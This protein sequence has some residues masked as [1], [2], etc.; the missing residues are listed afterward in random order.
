M[1]KS[2]E[3]IAETFSDVANLFRSHGKTDNPSISFLG[4]TEE[5]RVN[6]SGYNVDITNT[7]KRGYYLGEPLPGIVRIDDSNNV[8]IIKNNGRVSD[9]IEAGTAKTI[10]Q[11]SLAKTI[12]NRLIEDKALGRRGIQVR[13]EEGRLKIISGTYGSNSTIEVEPGCRQGFV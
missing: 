10:H 3:K 2:N 7:A 4:M 12:Q 6:P 9:A 5:T 11:A 1:K 8:L 13:L